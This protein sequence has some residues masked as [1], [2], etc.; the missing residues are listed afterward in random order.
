VRSAIGERIARLSPTTQEILHEASILGQQFSFEDLQGVGGRDEAAIEAALEEAMAASI[1]PEADRIGYAFHHVLIQQALEAELPVR[2]RQRMYRAAGESIERRGGHERRAAELVRYFLE[3][4]A[5][6]R[7][8]HFAL[9]AGEQAEA[10]YAHSEAE[11]HFR[12]ALDLASEVG[13]GER[14]AQ[15]REQLGQVLSTVAHYD[16]SLEMFA[17][18]AARYDALGDTDALLRVTAKIEHVHVRQ[19]TTQVGIAHLEAVWA[20][21]AALQTEP[22]YAR[23]LAM[24]WT[25]L[26]R[27]YAGGD[28]Y[29]EE[30]AATERSVEFARAAANP[31]L[32]AQAEVRRGRACI[33]LSRY[34]DSIQAIESALPVLEAEADLSGLCIALGYVSDAYFNR[35]ELALEEQSLERGLAIAEILGY[36]IGNWRQARADLEEGLGLI[37]EVGV[38]PD[39]GNML[40]WL[41]ALSVFEGK[42]EVAKTYFAEAEAVAGTDILSVDVM[43]WALAERDLLSGD[44]AAAQQRLIPHTDSPEALEGDNWSWQRLLLAAALTELG[45]TDEAR[46][47]VDS[48]LRTINA[49]QPRFTRIEAQRIQAIIQAHDHVEYPALV[50]GLEQALA[51]CRAMPYP[52]EEVRLLYTFGTVCAGQGK[53]ELARERFTAALAICGQLGERLYASRIE[54]EL[55]A[56]T[57]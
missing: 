21:F 12:L 50:A 44:P 49:E 5:P 38:A 16:A 54:Q 36:I 22:R 46:K 35:C 20:R 23:G 11:Y 33:D 26:A 43:L 30:L 2:R 25:A 42:P 7:A 56:L 4:D 48:L 53:P 29:A 14:E 6:E 28:R 45:E 1:I 41:G 47:V 17:A 51:W 24:L 8:L 52:H 34:E 15:A 27:L 10:V 40:S 37:R 9:H 18:A 3:G 13:D 57:E 19:S 31:H 55:A 32:L 39:I